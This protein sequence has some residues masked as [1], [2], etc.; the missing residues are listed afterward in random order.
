MAQDIV[1]PQ[2]LGA[3]P[4][5]FGGRFEDNDELS[6]GIVSSFAVLAFRGKVWRVKFRGVEQNLLTDKG[7]PMPSVEVV[8]VK[9]APHLSKLYYDG[10]F[11]EGDSRAPDCWSSNGVNPDRAVQN[12]VNSVCATCPKNEFGS[13][14]T[15]DGKQA[16]ACT[17]HK[18]LVVVPLDDMGN[19]LYGGPMLLRIPA[20]SLGDLSTYANALKQS[21][22]PFYAVGT[23]I[24]FDIDKAFPKL[25]M[26]P[27]RTLTQDEGAYIME[28]R[29]DPKT[30]RILNEVS[31]AQPQGEEQASPQF[32]QA[33]TQP[34]PQQARPGPAPQQAKAS[35]QPNKT[36][37]QGPAPAAAQAPKPAP[38]PAPAAAA[39]PPP[40]SRSVPPPAPKGTS[41]IGAAIAN[42]APRVAAPVARAAPPPP[43]PPATRTPPRAA[44]APAPAAPP[45]EEEAPQDFTDDLDS[46]LAQLMGA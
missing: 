3:L 33:P 32:E 12:P 7:D 23:R 29:D 28:L 36:P 40:A 5:V 21:G 30:L 17:D 4:A 6:G 35:P 9:S 25:V 26:N 43:P 8:L 46:Q 38:R 14:I 10:G 44:P 45:A 16:K 39:A 13:R 27:I 20:A 24:K 2:N 34:A 37:P 19:E 22:Y 18:R 11:S 1:I 15:D 42:P 41:A 31:E